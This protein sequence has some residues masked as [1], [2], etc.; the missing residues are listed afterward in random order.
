MLARDG[1]SGCVGYAHGGAGVADVL[2]DLFEATA[3]PPSLTPLA[4]LPNGSRCTPDRHRRRHW[5]T[6]PFLDDGED[7]AGRL[8]QRRSRRTR[9]LAHS[10]RTKPCEHSTTGRRAAWTTARGTRWM[11]PSQCHGPPGASRRSSTSLLQPAD[12]RC[13]VKAAALRSFLDAF[14]LSDDDR[15]ATSLMRVWLARPRRCC[16]SRSQN[17]QPACHRRL[18]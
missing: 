13:W 1:P 4:A 8:V 5:N 9:F 11:G 15:P 16:V 18:S 12:G 3:V 10:L 6:W 14:T 17:D 7:L 2:L